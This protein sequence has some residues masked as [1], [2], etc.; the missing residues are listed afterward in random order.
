MLMR[1][2]QIKIVANK[3]RGVSNNLMMRLEVGD[4]SFFNSSRSFGDKEKKATSELEI[5]AEPI[6]KSKTKPIANAIL[7]GDAVRKNREE[8][9]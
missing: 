4:C 2:F 9:T 1:L 3:D 8:S 7:T 6:N 5:S